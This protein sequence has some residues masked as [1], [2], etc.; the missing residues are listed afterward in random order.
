[1]IRD[2]LPCIFDLGAGVIH[3]V[4]ADGSGRAQAGLAGTFADAGVQGS[5]TE[6]IRVVSSPSGSG[7]AGRD[8]PAA[9]TRGLPHLVRGIVA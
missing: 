8:R 5:P 9:N 6:V 4:G 1:M 7:G 2:R 3:T